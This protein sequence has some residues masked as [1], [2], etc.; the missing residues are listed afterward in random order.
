MGGTGAFPAAELTTWPVSLADPESS[1]EENENHTDQRESM[2]QVIHS[3]R[4]A[5]S[6]LQASLLKERNLP[7][8]HYRADCLAVWLASAVLGITLDVNLLLTSL[9]KPPQPLHQNCTDGGCK[10]TNGPQLGSCKKK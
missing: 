7:C 6:V 10:K 8:Q 3:P 9:S 2:W 4:K 5:A 1:R